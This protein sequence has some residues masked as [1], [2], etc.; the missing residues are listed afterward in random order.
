MYCSHSIAQD[1]P[2]V[3]PINEASFQ[4]SYS[5]RR[6]PQTAAD[7]HYEKFGNC[8]RLHYWPAANIYHLECRPPRK[9]RN[10]GH[11]CL[12]AI[13]ACTSMLL[14]EA[15]P[16]KLEFPKSKVRIFTSAITV[17]SGFSR[18]DCEGRHQTKISVTIRSYR[19]SQDF[20]KNPP[21]STSISHSSV[22]S[23]LATVWTNLNSAASMGSTISKTK[24]IEK[25]PEKEQKSHLWRRIYLFWPERMR[26][27]IQ[28]IMRSER[29][30]DMVCKDFNV[31]SEELLSFEKLPR[32]GVRGEGVC[33]PLP[34]L[35]EA[36][37]HTTK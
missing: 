14:W 33:S 12:K 2:T 25:H 20:W 34:G 30:W 7:E 23:I 22:A 35:H 6:K 9:K 18:S 31:P 16:G 13:V 36:K 15:W 19:Q 3:Y 24:V 4:S 1:F 32:G 37:Y 17:H 5:E 27:A 26:L 11:P 10:D 28:R 29:L 8:V 21:P